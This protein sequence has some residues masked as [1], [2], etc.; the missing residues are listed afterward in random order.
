MKKVLIT[1]VIAILAIVMLG[2]I[3]NASTKNSLKTYLT[4]EKEIGG[5]TWE[6]SNQDKEKIGKFFSNNEITDE[7]ATKI[8]EIANKA[9]KFMSDN[10]ASEPDK[11]KTK[12]QKQQ[13]LD[14]AKEAA[15]VLGLTVNYDYSTKRLDVYKDGKKIDSLRWG[16]KKVIDSE[17][18]KTKYIITTE[19]SA[20]KTGSTNYIYAIV[21]GLV[22]I[23]GTTLVIAKRKNAN[24]NA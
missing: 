5:V 6:I 19:P 24:A 22:L 11:I 1:M 20:I 7:Q 9:I 23:A 18:G 15:S 10:G 12:A 3:S 4:T 21:T 8:E 16:T 17:T 13:L 2:T 14:Y